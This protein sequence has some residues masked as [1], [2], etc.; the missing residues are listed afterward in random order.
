MVD[1]F[2]GMEGMTGRD[3]CLKCGDLA[4]DGLCDNTV[5][6]NQT[7]MEYFVPGTE[8]TENCSCHVALSRCGQSGHAAGRYCPPEQ[9]EKTAWLKEGTAGTPDA[10]AVLDPKIA[11][12]CPIHSS[13]WDRFFSEEE[14]E[15]PVSPQP[16]VPDREEP[17][18]GW[19]NW[20][21]WLRI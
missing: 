15:D 18:G 1:S 9:V 14:P 8:P 20:R 10:E 7:R 4:V 3:I 16:E 19:F 11:G 12:T 13:W 17:H 21:D 5:Q 2:T 6:G